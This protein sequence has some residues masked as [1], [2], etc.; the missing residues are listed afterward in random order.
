MQ[1]HP[2][3]LESSLLIW[4]LLTD[5]FQNGAV[6]EEG[7]WI[8][9]KPQPPCWVLLADAPPGKQQPP[10]LITLLPDLHGPLIF[11]TSDLSG[12]F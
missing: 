4:S 2:F 12:E 11:K 10:Q 8:C 3:R 7:P 1:G 9:L 5:H 6:I